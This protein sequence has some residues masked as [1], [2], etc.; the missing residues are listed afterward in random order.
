MGSHTGI[1]LISND[2]SEK[3]YIGQGS[4]IYR[5]WRQH[6]HLLTTG[7]HFVEALQKDWAVLGEKAF[8][9]T[10]LLECSEQ[11]LDSEE[12]RILA[13]VPEHLKYNRGEA[14][15]KPT[16][17]LARSYTS[18]LRQSRARGSQPFFQKNLITGEI[19]RFEYSA[20]VTDDKALRDS[21]NRCL[22]GERASARGFA[23]FFDPT[24]VPE[25]K[26][27]P[28]PVADTHRIIV[29][30]ELATGQEIQWPYVA[31]VEKDGFQRTGVIKCLKGE[32]NTHRGFTWRYADGLPHRNMSEEHRTKL[33]IGARKLGG[34]RAIIGTN[35]TTG[36]IVPFPYARAAAAALGIDP[37]Y[38][39]LALSGRLKEA[40]GF[41]WGYADG[42][43]HKSKNTNEGKSD[44]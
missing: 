20:D 1:Y 15:N 24:F 11:D 26:R 32:M 40:G 30:T 37:S 14:G 12:A 41:S 3:A 4:D 39:H 38:I 27:K 10:I 42:L 2:V 19:R 28:R 31:S 33:T 29:G 23:Y 43:P 35:Q 34:S 21:I 18:K 9:F 13:E 16:L 17:G 36:E 44:V 5:R 7:A 25:Q 22:S 8:S 6:R